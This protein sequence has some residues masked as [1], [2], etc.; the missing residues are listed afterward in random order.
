MYVGLAFT[1][2][3]VLTTLFLEPDMYKQDLL[4]AIWSLRVKWLWSHPSEF[5]RPQRESTTS[6]V[7]LTSTPCPNRC[8]RSSLPAASLT[9]FLRWPIWCSRS[10]AGLEGFQGGWGWHTGYRG[11]GPNE[12]KGIMQVC[13]VCLGLKEVTI[14]LLRVL[15]HKAAWSG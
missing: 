5:P 8:S 1:A 12:L 13:S 3:S 11:G 4:R 7:R 9:A 6:L 14:P 10:P 15:Y 2:P